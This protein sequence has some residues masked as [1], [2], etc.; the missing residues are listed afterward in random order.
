MKELVNLAFA[1]GGSG[2]SF[3]EQ[4][5]VGVS[6]L[7]VGRL[8]ARSGSTR[9]LCLRWMKRRAQ[10]D[11]VEAGAMSGAGDRHSGRA[12]KGGYDGFGNRR[13]VPAV[14]DA[15]PPLEATLPDRQLATRVDRPQQFGQ[16]LA[17]LATPPNGGGCAYRLLTVAGAGLAE[18]HAVV[19]E[20]GE[21]AITL[22]D[23]ESGEYRLPPEGFA[24]WLPSYWVL[25]G[26]GVT[27]SSYALEHFVY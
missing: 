18:T 10:P 2:V 22:F 25:N 11:V 21:D 24:R 17:Q 9:T 5:A 7:A 23:P 4:D 3:S 15:K 27:R 1:L 12:R 19:A 16:L 20:V 6:W 8:A 26:H 13:I 14:D